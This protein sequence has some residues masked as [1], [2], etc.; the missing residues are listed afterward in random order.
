MILAQFNVK[1]RHHSV[2]SQT[3]ST[4]VNHSYAERKDRLKCYISFYLLHCLPVFGS[5]STW[6]QSSKVIK[7]SIIKKINQDPCEVYAIV[8]HLACPV[9]D[10][11]WFLRCFSQMTSGWRS[12]LRQNQCATPHLD[13]WLFPG[14]NSAPPQYLS[15]V[16]FLVSVLI[17][18]PPLTCT[19]LTS[20]GVFVPAAASLSSSCQLLL[21]SSLSGCCLSLWSC[22]QEEACV[23]GGGGGSTTYLIDQK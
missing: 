13:L 8:K 17:Y 14:G 12:L 18:S 7:R 23:F 11:C 20:S 10:L 5:V 21:V 3:K 1:L 22:K 2:L 6:N 9:R 4:T 19:S 15:R 16:L